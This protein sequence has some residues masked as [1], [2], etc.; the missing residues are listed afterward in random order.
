MH[1]T[2]QPNNQLIEELKQRNQQASGLAQSLKAQG[3][4]AG[5]YMLRIERALT[6]LATK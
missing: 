1:S 6:T 5:E 2:E 4:K 3:D